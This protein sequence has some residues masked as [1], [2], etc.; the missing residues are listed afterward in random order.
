MYMIQ[1][2]FVCNLSVFQMHF[3]GENISQLCQIDMCAPVIEIDKL[4]TRVCHIRS[5]QTLRAC[6]DLLNVRFFINLLI[7]ICGQSA[8]CA[9]NVL[10]DTVRTQCSLRVLLFGV[11]YH[12]VAS[13]LQESSIIIQCSP[14]T[15]CIHVHLHN[16]ITQMAICTFVLYLLNLNCT[17]YSS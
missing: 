7:I 14:F 2:I 9:I 13:S 3:A 10:F 6:A 8:S 12:A 17:K 4:I 16:N 5:R 11:D 15:G 1:V